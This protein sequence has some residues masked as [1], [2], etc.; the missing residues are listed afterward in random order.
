[1]FNKA[2]FQISHLI[3]YWYIL[4]TA[5]FMFPISMPVLPPNPLYTVCTVVIVSDH[6]LSVKS[7]HNKN[8]NN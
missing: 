4:Y 3:I 6:F 8:M 7:G 2:Y 5:D 1:M